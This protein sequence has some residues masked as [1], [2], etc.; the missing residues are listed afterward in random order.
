[1]FDRCCAIEAHYFTLWLVLDVK[2]ARCCRVT[3]NHMEKF[4]EKSFSWE[5]C[6][7]YFG[8]VSEIRKGEE[9]VSMNSK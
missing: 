6:A 1:M 7:K 2:L 3:K 5:K 9:N 4:W 8:L